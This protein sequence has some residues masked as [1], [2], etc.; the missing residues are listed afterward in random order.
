MASDLEASSQV[1]LR[2]PGDWDMWISII[3]KFAKTRNVWEYIDPDATDKPT[4]ATPTQPTAGRVRPGATEI[5]QL[6]KDEISKFQI[7]ENRYNSELRTH[8]DK[9]RALVEIQEHIVKT[10]GKYYRSITNKDGVA[11]ELEILKSRVKPTDWARED[12]VRT[13]YQETLKAAKRT[14][15]E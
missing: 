8:R 7:L 12:E 3:R 5:E 15:V 14:K 9:T 6:E 1:I 2:G 11:E 13:R 10:A 4:L